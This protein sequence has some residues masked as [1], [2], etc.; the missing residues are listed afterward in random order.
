MTLRSGRFTAFLIAASLCLIGCSDD[1]PSNGPSDGPDRSSP[2]PSSTRS[3]TDQTVVLDDPTGELPDGT[4]GG[5]T[6]GL[7]VD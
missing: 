2:P 7:S 6:T 3:P 5:G 1:G 4:D